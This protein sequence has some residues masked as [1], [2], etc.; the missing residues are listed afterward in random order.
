MDFKQLECFIAV[1]EKKSFSK[2]SEAL[3]I[4]QPAVTSNIQKLE[5]WLKVKL[6][7]RGTKEI[8][9]TPEGELLYAYANELLNLRGQ[10]LSELSRSRFLKQGTLSLNSSTIPAQ[11]IVPGILN[12]FKKNFEQFSFDMSVSSSRDV[13]E[14]IISGKINIGFIGS[15]PK[16]K[17]LGYVEL[18]EDELLMI[19]S[20]E[21]K[22]SRPTVSL[23]EIR[24]FDLLIRE[25]GSS[26]RKILENA[27]FEQ[28][29]S[30]DYF[31]SVSE[32][33]SSQAIK[34]LVQLS[35]GIGFVSAM[36]IKNELAL[37]LLNAYRVKELKLKRYFRMAYAR[38]RHFSPAEKAFKDFVEG[39]ASK[40][41]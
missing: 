17:N 35:W 25:D 7:N 28:N 26:T 6:I 22:F 27:L 18:Q 3:F 32:V 20:K 36:D 30:S 12:D 5:N 24:Q 13:L 40:K 2:A 41:N 33:E 39:W 8:S 14:D 1:I 34:T 23:S 16:N 38:D 21:I 19:C 10:A 29:K 15:E 9:L 31:K 4:S 11:Y 37:G